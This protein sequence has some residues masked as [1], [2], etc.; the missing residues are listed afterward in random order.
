MF[1]FGIRIAT[2]VG[3]R[4]LFQDFL[5]DMH[6]GRNSWRVIAFFSTAALAVTLLYI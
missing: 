2:A 6:A 3:M 1:V 5:L 4:D